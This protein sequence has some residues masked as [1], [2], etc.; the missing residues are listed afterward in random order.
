MLHPLV[1]VLRAG[2]KPDNGA[3]LSKEL[4][5]FLNCDGAAAGG[6]D[7]SDAADQALNDFGFQRAKVFFAVLFENRGNGLSRFVRDKRVGIDQ[8]EAGE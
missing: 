7:K 2:I 1:Q 8:R 4:A 6:D 3:D 5:I